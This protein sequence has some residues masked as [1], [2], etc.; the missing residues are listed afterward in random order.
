MR[1][2]RATLAGTLTAAATLAATL[3]LPAAAQAAT[4]AFTRTSQ[5]PGGYVASFTVQNDTDAPLGGWRVEFDLPAS[6][7]IGSHWNAELHREGDHYV[8]TD[9]GWNGVLLPGASTSF[10][11]LAT[12][13]ADPTGCI[14]NGDPCAPTALPDLRSPA[15]P[16]NVRV[17]IDN[18][19]S[20][21]WEPATDNVGVVR[22]QIYESGTLWREVTGTS[23]VVT[24]GNVL[25]P[26]VYVWA[27]RAVDAAGN[28][29][30]SGF[31]SLGAAWTGQDPPP[32]PTGLRVTSAAGGVVTLAWDRAP[33]LPF[34]D[35][36]IAGYEVSVDGVLADRVGANSARVRVSGAG[37]HQLTVRAFNAHDRYSTPTAV[38]YP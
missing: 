16:G 20:L 26:K 15:A 29:G 5:W 19:V 28:V 22:Y 21:A 30:P 31:T 35:P 33:W 25:P 12:G 4:V 11:W 32:A 24:T 3:V 23:A 13:D 37:R 14:V 7:R 10:G 17:I 2:F 8:F 1:S 9:L 27:V 18:G 34:A 36:P 6:T 38:T